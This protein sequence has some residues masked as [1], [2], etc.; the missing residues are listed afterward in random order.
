MAKQGSDG[1]PPEPPA[2]D[3][4]MVSDL[5][6]T[7][8]ETIGADGVDI[9][10]G[11]DQNI[12]TESKLVK[13]IDEPS[14]DIVTSK[15]STVDLEAGV[16]NMPSA[17]PAAAAAAL[18][19]VGLIP[20]PR[21]PGGRLLL[22][23]PT[24]MIDRPKTGS[25]K[26]PSQL[27]RLEKLRTVALAQIAKHQ[28]KNLEEKLRNIYK[29]FH[30]SMIGVWLTKIDFWLEKHLSHH[31]RYYYFLIFFQLFPILFFA[32]RAKPTLRRKC[33]EPLEVN[34]VHY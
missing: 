10:K 7:D 22:A 30:S 27:Q 18:N 2:K 17:P 13:V 8:L 16:E 15:V 31:L 25:A 6:L 4:M 20:P 5:S 24:P 14:T 32:F 21:T 1:V 28:P 11:I 34:V 29:N 23:P 26:P 9:E 19:Q 33:D 12:E 3:D